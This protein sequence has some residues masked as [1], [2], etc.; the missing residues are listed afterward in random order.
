MIVSLLCDAGLH[1]KNTCNLSTHVSGTIIDLFVSEVDVTF[2]SVSVLSVGSVGSSDHA[3]AHTCLPLS[4]RHSMVAGF[5]RVL[6]T[7]GSEWDWGLASIDHSLDQLASTVEVMTLSVQACLGDQTRKQ[8]RR[9]RR[10]LDLVVW[11]RDA[12]Y[13]LIGHLCS[14]TRTVGSNPHRKSICTMDFAA[15]Q[16]GVHADVDAD[17]SESLHRKI[18]AA[19]WRRTRN[20]VAHFLKLRATDR[21][22]GERFL[23][24][25]LKPRVPLDISLSVDGNEGSVSL[26]GASCLPALQEHLQ[27]IASMSLPTDLSWQSSTADMVAQIRAGS[28]YLYA[29]QVSTVVPFKSA[30]LDEVLCGMKRSSLAY[31]GSY[32]SVKAA[33]SGGRRLTLA[34]CNQAVSFGLVPTATAF[35]EFIPIRKQGPRVVRL[36]RNIRPISHASELSAVLDGLILLRCQELFVTWWGPGQCGGVSEALLAVMVVICTCQLRSA[37]GLAIFWFFADLASAF[38]SIGHDDIRRA[39]FEAGVM[40]K[41]WLIIDDLLRSDC[42][43]INVNGVSSSIFQLV[44]GTAQGRKISAHLFNCVM[45]YLHNYIAQASGGVEVVSPALVYPQTRLVDIQYSDD[46]AAPAASVCQ[47]TALAGACE[48]FTQLHGTSFNIGPRK[49]AILGPASVQ[50]V[51]YC[52]SVIPYVSQYTYLGVLIDSELTFHGLLNQLIARG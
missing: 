21:N 3:L 5:G 51:L 15:D 16:E 11:L 49:T 42:A 25:I 38:D 43:S 30:E 14:A 47:L 45:R 40:G 23:S 4:L 24:G 12:W 39:V 17:E 2:P 8:P 26:A 44:G 52:G 48:R 41:L 33:A 20:I 9:R 7:G 36:L 50:S 34:I 13:V 18:E 37:Q 27:S 31:R 32:A 19:E 28:G 1:C 35:R 10:V 22:Q 6:W 29:N 46:L